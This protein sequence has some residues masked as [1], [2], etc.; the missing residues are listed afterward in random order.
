M[1]AKQG[2]ETADDMRAWPREHQESWYIRSFTRFVIADDDKGYIREGRN[3]RALERLWGFTKTEAHELQLRAL[4][5]LVDMSREMDDGLGPVPAAA[6][7]PTQ[8]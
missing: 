1:P 8:H 4:E 7:L 2:F 3:L 5:A 6:P